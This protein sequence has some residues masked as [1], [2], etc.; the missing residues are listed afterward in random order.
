MSAQDDKFRNRPGEDTSTRRTAE[1]ELMRGDRGVGQTGD[2]TPGGSGAAGA[3]W[4]M[5]AAAAC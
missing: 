5:K 1:E 3:A 4:R 2:G